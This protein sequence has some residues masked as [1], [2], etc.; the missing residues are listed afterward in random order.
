[1]S[2]MS[3]GGTAGGMGVTV[4]G[5]D[6]VVWYFLRVSGLALVVLAGVHMAITHFINV[7]T[8]TT[9]EFVA[10]RW[11]NPLWRAFDWLLLISAL[12]HGVLGLR[13][14]IADY[15]RSPGLR[16][17]GMALMWVVGVVFMAIGSITIFTFDAEMARNNLGPLSGEMWIAE[18]I[19]VMLYLI[20]A[21]TY[22]GIVAAVIWVGRS[23]MRGGLPV[24]SGDPGQ[25]AWVFHR[26]TGIGILFFL[27]IHIVDIM[28]VGLGRDVYDHSVE[29]Y[30]RAELIPMEI[31]L[32]GAVIY[33]TLNGLRV[34]AID[35]TSWGYRK[36]RQMFYWAL[37]LT[38]VLTLWS[39]W[40][41]I[42]TH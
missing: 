23:L 25:Y 13:Y 6:R 34:I 36:E 8:D 30:G 33:H 3:T 17:A 35:F 40:I 39:G 14:S 1:M 2:A 24:Y 11:A 19:G 31:A 22:I 32:V 16:V 9:F 29:F 20:A 12:W 5:A 37:V 4:P 10:N 15:L 18:A 27:L 26:A 21:G 38:T 41:L 7:P 28:L 42:A